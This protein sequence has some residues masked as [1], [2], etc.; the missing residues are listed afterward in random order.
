MHGPGGVF[1][2]TQIEVDEGTGEGKSQNSAGC[3]W[4]NAQWVKEGLIIWL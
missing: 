2:P 1:L 4:K 3:V